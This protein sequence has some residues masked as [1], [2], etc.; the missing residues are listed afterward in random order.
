MPTDFYKTLGV[1]KDASEGEI[2]KAYRKLARK[3]HPDIN[4][5]NSE[6]EKKFKEISQAYDCLGNKEKRALYD[7]FGEDGLQ[8]GFDA[9]KAREY[10]QWKGFQQGGQS[11][12]AEGFGR[13]QSYEDIFGDIFGAGMGSSGFRSQT[14]SRGKDLQHDMTIDLISAL[15]GFETE[16]SM[17][18]AKICGTCGGSGNDPN[19]KLST[20]TY[21]GGSGRLNVAEGPMHFTKP[22]PHCQG[23]GQ[24]GKPCPTC[25]GSGQVSGTERIR[26]VIPKGVKEGSKVRVAGKGEPASTGG[27]PGDLYLIIHI[28]PHPFLTRKGDDL[29]MDVPVTVREAMAGGTIDIPTVDGTVKLK[30]PSGSQTGNI[31]RLKG[32]GATNLKTKTK[33]NFL[34]K[35][36]VKVPQTEDPE[37]LAAVQK[38]DGIYKGDVRSGIRI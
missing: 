20:C 4:P 2:K 38:M 35:L 13:Y 31:L 24:T 26:V 1:S 25:G 7:E 19:S 3:W 30:V 17:Q 8:A 32:K 27:K 14:P 37:I 11:H 12:G 10:S 5:G 29:H 16:L 23:Y 33:G 28:K 15:K 6:A 18:K 21:C 9:Q 22:C 34:V 36:V